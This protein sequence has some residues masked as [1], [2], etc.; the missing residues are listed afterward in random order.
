MSINGYEDRLSK[1]RMKCDSFIDQRDLSISMLIPVVLSATSFF[2]SLVV[3]LILIVYYLNN[4]SIHYAEATAVFLIFS[5]I[6]LSMVTLYIFIADDCGWTDKRQYLIDLQLG[7]KYKAN[8]KTMIFKY[9]FT[10]LQLGLV[11][12]FVEIL[13]L[14]FKYSKSKDTREKAIYR[15]LI[16]YENLRARQADLVKVFTESTLQAIIQT[17]VYCGTFSKSISILFTP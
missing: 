5:L 15:K 13:A 8:I 3:D 2:V 1:K 11:V 17:T 6:I 10:I 16:K 14:C 7:K 12:R 4:S 9:I